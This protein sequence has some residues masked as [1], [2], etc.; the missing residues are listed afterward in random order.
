WYAPRDMPPKLAKFEPVAEAPRDMDTTHWWQDGWREL[1]A[2]RNE[3]DD[4]LRWPLDVQVAGPLPPL[5][6]QLEQRGWKLQAQAGWQQA[7]TMLDTQA[8]P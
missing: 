7:L 8:T 4:D 2:R 6:R 3:F 5:Q 1:P